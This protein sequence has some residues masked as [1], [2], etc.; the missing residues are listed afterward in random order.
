VGNTYGYKNL[1]P[2]IK[3]KSKYSEEICERIVN[4]KN[5]GLSW[6][7]IS[8]LLS[9]PEGTACSILY[10]RGLRLLKAKEVINN[11]Q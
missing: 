11:S 8:R 6:G 5:K 9:I 2:K 4:L 7:N 3:G 1:I 10:D